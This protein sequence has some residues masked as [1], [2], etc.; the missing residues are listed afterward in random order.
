MHNV[1]GLD[2]ECCWIVNLFEVSSEEALMVVLPFDEA[3]DLIGELRI[4]YVT[5]SLVH[6]ALIAAFHGWNFLVIPQTASLIA[7]LVLN[8][9]TDD[10]KN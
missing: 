7:S 6:R 4:R 8:L 1:L 9:T 3:G 5:T 10:V 2:L